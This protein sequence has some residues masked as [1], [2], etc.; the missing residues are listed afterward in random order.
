MKSNEI[1]R[2]LMER[3]GLKPT[4]LAMRMG[5]SKQVVNNRLKKSKT[6]AVLVEV[7][8]LMDYK[9]VVVP[10]STRIKPDWYEVTVEE[11]E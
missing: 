3:Q 2:S 11:Q 10:S 9:V 6:V 1:V 5:V 7:C 8:K 4:S